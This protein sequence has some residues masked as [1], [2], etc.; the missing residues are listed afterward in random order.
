LNKLLE[1]K[2]K[3]DKTNYQHDG[4]DI[5]LVGIIYVFITDA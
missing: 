3:D 5:F 2:K 4:H 1:M